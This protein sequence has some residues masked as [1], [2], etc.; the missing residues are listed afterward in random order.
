LLPDALQPLVEH[1][2]TSALLLDFDG[3]L[4][5]IVEDPTAARPLPEVPDLLTGLAARFATVAV[6]SGRPVA[7]LSEMLQQPK[8]VRLVGLYGLEWIDAAGQ[9][10]VVPEATP[11]EDVIAAV[12]ASARQLAPPGVYVE[13]KGLT[14]TLHWRHA[15]EQQ[16]WIER[17]VASEVAERG[18]VA[19]GSKFSL[20]L[21]PPLQVDKGTVATGL[22]E[23]MTAV[24]AFGDDWG[25]LPVFRA[26]G[27]LSHQGV[28]VARVA[29]AHGESPPEVS[30]EADVVVSSA[31]GAVGLLQLLLRAAAS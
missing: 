16:G 11:W 6:I 1:P 22:T 10:A 31:A 7:F 2:E 29:V 28:V 12:A 4:S 15:P 8:G 14:V 17:F 27:Q 21:G 26:L 9:R 3:T 30:A 23:G 19:H 5:L 18:L 25:D 24:A 13:P 20:E